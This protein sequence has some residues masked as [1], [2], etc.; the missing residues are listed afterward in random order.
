[1]MRLAPGA[2]MSVP[3]RASA[4]PS[5]SPGIHRKVAVSARVT[6]PLHVDS[7]D[8]ASTMT[9][10]V[11]SRVPA[12]VA[13][14]MRRSPSIRALSPTKVPKVTSTGPCTM[15]SDK[16][17]AAGPNSSEV[18]ASG[19]SKVPPSI[20]PPVIITGTLQLDCARSRVPPWRVRVPTAVP[21]AR[22]AVAPADTRNSPMVVSL[23]V[24]RSTVFPWPISARWVVTAWFPAGSKVPPA[25]VTRAR[26][27]TAA[28]RETTPPPSQRSASAKSD[29][30]SPSSRTV[31][32]Y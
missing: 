31:P 9:F 32:A 3:L 2:R 24:A 23:E 1:M 28:D 4:A 29:S 25:K 10:P 20:R 27:V 12:S 22:R 18:M 5:Y 7:S 14:C 17:E 6:S 21:A 11:S 30:I 13:P 16:V 15:T 8:P 26:R 19:P